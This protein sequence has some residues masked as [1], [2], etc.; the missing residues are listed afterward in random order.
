MYNG[1]MEI[2][3]ERL[4]LRPLG[5]EYLE[6]TH[7]YVSDPENTRL[8]MFLPNESLEETADYLRCCAEEWAKPEPAIYEF[9][10]LLNGAH[11]GHVTLELNGTRDTAELAWILHPAHHGRGYAVE[12]ARAM[13]TYARESLGITRFIAH[14]DSE[15]AASQAVMR[16]LGLV[17]TDATGTRKNRGSDD[18]RREYLYETPFQKPSPLGEGGSRA[19]RDG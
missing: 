18:L 16:K 9:A 15:N 4:V 10:V 19:A 2:I 14:C 12:A 8:M 6:S 7:V 13:M 3:S 17:L 5:P 1:A 11:I